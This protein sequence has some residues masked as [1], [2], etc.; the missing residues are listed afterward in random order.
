[1]KNLSFFGVLI[2]E[3]SF[4]AM[5]LEYLLELVH[6][7]LE[8][9]HVAVLGRILGTIEYK[10][11]K[12]LSPFADEVIIVASLLKEDYRKRL[13]IEET[14][15]AKQILNIIG[16]F[17]YMLVRSCFW[18]IMNFRE[19]LKIWSRVVENFSECNYSEIWYSRNLLHQ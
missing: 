1:M 16:T 14:I 15:N 7:E 4:L 8:N 11:I 5:R 17:V 2:K 10:N 18:R 19:L 12:Q 6:L 13:A 3:I 9:P